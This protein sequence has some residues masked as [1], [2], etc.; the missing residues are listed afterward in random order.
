MNDLSVWLATSRLTAVVPCS[1]ETCDVT[2]DAK[3]GVGFHRRLR[4]SD[5][6][7]PQ[8][9]PGVATN[10]QPRNNVRGA[11]VGRLLGRQRITKS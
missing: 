3:D 1:A 7:L 5:E 8:Q 11:V 9:S 4:K 10:A 2:S 6:R